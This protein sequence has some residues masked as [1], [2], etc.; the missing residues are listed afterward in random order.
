MLGQIGDARAVEPLLTALLTAPGLGGD[1]EVTLRFLF[2]EDKMEYES[3]DEALIAIGAP[4][5]DQLLTI[6][7]SGDERTRKSSFSTM[8]VTSP[9]PRSNTPL[10]SN[11]GVSMGW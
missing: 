10:S 9:T 8:S 11:M 5:V 3:A 7:G 6:A 4:A 2:E 1:F